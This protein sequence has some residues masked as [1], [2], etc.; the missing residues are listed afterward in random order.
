MGT[1]LGRP[2]R[3]C[4]CPSPD[5]RYAHPGLRSLDADCA[6]PS[7]ASLVSNAGSRA[8]AAPRFVLRWGRRRRTRVSERGRRF[9][10]VAAGFLK[11]PQV[12]NLR[13]STSGVL[14]VQVENLHPLIED[15]PESGRR[16]IT[17]GTRRRVCFLCR[18]KTCTH[19]SR[20]CP[21]VAAGFQPAESTRVAPPRADR[22]E[23]LRAARLSSAAARHPSRQSP[24][25]FAAANTFRMSATNSS[26][27]SN[28]Q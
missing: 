22:P 13:N 17:C 5:A 24:A 6:S 19:L 23:H 21:K 28:S 4:P 14:P 20:T 26:G 15:L 1:S 25:F 18:L 3:G 12:F 7:M 9:S 11:W 10:K 8:R 2:A 27:I 16:F